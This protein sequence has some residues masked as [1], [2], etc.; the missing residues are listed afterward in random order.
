MIYFG[1]RYIR[2]KVANKNTCRIVTTSAAE[3]TFGFD[4]SLYIHAY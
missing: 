2:S 1:R 3:L 4:W